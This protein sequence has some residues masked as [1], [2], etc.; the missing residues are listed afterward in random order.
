LFRI[1]AHLVQVRGFGC[2]LWLYIHPTVHI[3]AWNRQSRLMPQM[4]WDNQLLFKARGAGRIRNVSLFYEY[5]TSLCPRTKHRR[6]MQ[7]KVYRWCLRW[8]NVGAWSI[9]GQWYFLNGSLVGCLLVS[10]GI[11]STHFYPDCWH[12]DSKNIIIEF[13]L[14]QVRKTGQAPVLD[15]SCGSKVNQP[16]Y[17]NHQQTWQSMLPASL[18]NNT[19]HKGLRR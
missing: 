16:T 18:I 19:S 9:S 10:Q 12:Q 4:M 7:M 3:E 5:S 6:A 13:F 14:T 15:S 1:M 2:N 11:R 8:G 17:K